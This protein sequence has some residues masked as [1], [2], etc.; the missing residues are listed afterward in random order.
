VGRRSQLDDLHQKLLGQPTGTAQPVAIVA[1]AGMGGVGKTALARAYVRDHQANYPGGIWWLRVKGVDLVSEILTIAAIF[2]WEVPDLPIADPQQKQIQQV[3]WCWQQWQTQSPGTRLLVLDDVPTYEDVRHFLPTDA[4]FRI[5]LTSRVRFGRPVERLDLD[6]LDPD[7]ALVLLAE[8]IGAEDVRLADLDMAH[9][10]LKWLGYLPLGIELVGKYLERRPS[11]T[12]EKLWQRLQE[13]RLDA[14]A[15]TD[16][17]E[18]RV[19]EY[20]LRAA[21]DLSWQALSP[22]AQQV[23]GLVASFALAPIP[24]PLIGAA[25]SSVD[26]ED[27]EDALDG[28][29]VRGSM[30]QDLGAGRYQLHQLVWEYVRDQLANDL[31]EVAPALQQGMVTALVAQAKT[32]NYIVTLSDL[33]RM[34]DV[35]PHLTQLAEEY[36]STITDENVIWPVMA[37]ARLAEGQ[38]RWQEAERWRCECLSITETRFGPDHP[39]VATSLNNLAL[40]HESMGRYEEAEPLHVRSLAIWEQKFGSNHFYVASSLNNLA[41]LYRSMERHEEAAPLYKR[42][43]AIR[44]QQFGTD[45]PSTAESL[46]GLALLYKSME[47]YKA[48]ELLYQRSLAIREQQLGT[49]HPSVATILNNLAELYR[50]ME[51]YGEAEPLVVRSLSIWEQQLGADHPHVATSLNNLA[52]LHES[53]GCYGEA[54]PLYVRSLE[55]S[56][57]KLLPDHPDIQSRLNNFVGMVQAALAAGQVDQLSDHPMTQGI[58][59]QLQNGDSA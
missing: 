18:E 24:Q 22:T 35:V 56:F 29:L 54:E 16:L 41:G 17:P 4:S 52:L 47:R 8:L 28:E 58:L 44:E 37:L 3:A 21:L 36:S 12:L 53:M 19:Y 45:H 38:S 51:R 11:V 59:K 9:C 43:L 55:I 48:A 26:E 30:V 1:A 6:V 40:L 50:A 33:V 31:K 15:V 42:S 13:K 14:R 2:G 49:D 23:A 27:L 7:T 32:V 20:N 10:I 25:L 34:Q 39:H 57:K 46:N 5:L